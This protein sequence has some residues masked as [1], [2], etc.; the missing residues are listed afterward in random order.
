MPGMMARTRGERSV[1][2]RELG[3]E[4]LRMMLTIGFVLRT[5]SHDNYSKPENAKPRCGLYLLR[6]D[7]N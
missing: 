7:G 2:A 4:G 1:G 5:P 6:A 3:L